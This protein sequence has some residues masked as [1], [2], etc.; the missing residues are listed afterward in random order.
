MAESSC[1]AESA[2]PPAGEAHLWCLDPAL[3]DSVSATR[4][5]LARLPD[6]ERARY[7]TYRTP[8]SSNQYLATRALVRTV[9]SRYCG[10][11][12]ERLRFSASPSG[13][14]ELALP[15]SPNLRFSLSNTRGL[16][17]VLVASVRE[18]GVDAEEMAPLDVLEI[19]DRFF[20]A[21]ESQ[22]LRDRAEPERAHRFF[23]LWTLKEAYLK[24]R[25]L[26]V[27]T[28]PLA[29]I[30]FGRTV[31]GA[32]SPDFGPAI[33][34]DPRAWQFDL[35]RLTEK[36]AVATCVARGDGDARIVVRRLEAADIL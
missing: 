5:W 35:L 28:L 3:V 22:E 12:V 8:S 2:L 16:V 11:A 33:A 20:A 25:G 19:A 34:D 15:V 27:F 36:H 4:A 29:E 26:G 24:A 6:D 32:V 18:V 21:A 10:L 17:V 31:A 9:L 14:P 30:S 13:R 23:E 7:E 1:G